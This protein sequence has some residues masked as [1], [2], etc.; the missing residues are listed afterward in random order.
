M[1][2]L[3]LYIW[4]FFPFSVFGNTFTQ[5]EVNTHT[6]EY[7]SYSTNSE[8]HDIHIGISEEGSSLTEIIKDYSGVSG[9]NGVFFCPADYPQCK[10]KNTTINERFI[11]GQEIAT[12]KSTGERVVFWW[13]TEQN[14]FLYQTERINPDKRGE[15]Y[16]WFANFPL[17]LQ[18]GKNKLEHYYDIGLIGNKMRSK[19]TR[20]FVCST[21][22]WEDIL[23]GTISEA[24]MDDMVWVLLQI[25]CYHAL[26]LDAGR[27]SSF[28]YNGRSRRWPG[29]EVL[30][31]IVISRNDIDTQAIDLKVDKIFQNITT[32][33]L[34]K[35]N[36]QKSITKLQNY[37]KTIYNTQQKIYSWY[38][39]MVVDSDGNTIG[40]T[41]PS[42]PKNAFR[43]VYILNT[44]DAELKI[45][46]W[47][48]QT[49]I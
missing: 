41:L 39:E 22:E 47:K 19:L 30:D 33:Y 12:Y 27:S 29:R 35:P 6:V 44:I 1:K 26:N 10:G 15:I 32:S 36:Y 16:E 48:M 24:N 18:S 23:F 3:Y 49:Q 17:L 7:I 8:I 42:L 28:I 46:I 13:D 37:R 31:G 34:R 2:K 11:N 5:I 9:I 43:K 21:Q 40:Y 45:L 20:H 25:G 14:P 4:L 38:Q